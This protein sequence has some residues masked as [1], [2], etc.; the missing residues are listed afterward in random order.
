MSAGK[1]TRALYLPTYSASVVHP[2]RVQPETLTL[3]VGGT[4]NAGATGESLILSP[5]SA[6]VGGGRRKLGLNARTVTI[7]LV[8]ATPPTGYKTEAVISLPVLK[9]EVFDLLKPRPQVAYLGKTWQ[10]TF[11]TEETAK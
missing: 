5:I 8:D 9:P 1:F 10:V 11:V 6:R 7:Q 2:I 4:P 3:T